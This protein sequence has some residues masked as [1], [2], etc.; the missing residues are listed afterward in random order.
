MAVPI[1][2]LAIHNPCL[3]RMQFEPA[4]LEPLPDTIKHIFCL[5]LALAVKHRIISVSGIPNAGEMSCHP[6]I[7]RVVQK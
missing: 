4:G 7:K 5:A 3:A 2:V 6:Q 1:D